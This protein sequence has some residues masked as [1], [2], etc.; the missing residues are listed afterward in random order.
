MLSKN[1]VAVSSAANFID[2]PGISPF[3]PS[4][5]YPELQ[6]MVSI[7]MEQNEVYPLLR[8]TMHSLEMDSARWG[9]TSWNPLAEII[10]PGQNVLIKPNL[11]RHLHLS[12]GDY[13]AVVTHGSVIRAVLDYVALALKGEGSIIVGDAPV[14]SADFNKIIEKTDLREVCEDVSQTWGVPISIVDFRLWT[15]QLDK[16]HCVTSS[17]DLPGDPN[18]YIAVDLSNK[19]LLAPISD[20]FERFRVTNYDCEEMRKHHNQVKHEYL[21]ARSVLNA[22]VVINLPKLKTH[23]K[24][25]LTAA[26]KNVVGINGHKDWLPHHRYGSV[27][28]GGDEYL[29][30]SILKR[31]RSR[32]LQ[33]IDREPYS[34]MNSYLRMI[35]RVLSRLSRHISGDLF[36]EGSWYGNDT[37][38]RTV[39]DLNRVV[40]YANKDGIMCDS[41]QRK[42]L[43]I[44]DGII[45]GEGEGPME[46]DRKQCGILVGGIN[47]VAVD[48]ALATLV[49]FDYRKVPVISNAFGI[50]DWPI[51]EFSPK[52]IQIFTNNSR[53]D[54]LR[55]GCSFR[56][57]CLKPPSGWSGH[58]ELTNA[59]NDD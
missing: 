13:R 16:N 36:E 26:L 24:V 32:L 9:T 55:I 10:Q 5:V 48:A 34:K 53:F 37:L 54:D 3:R 31:L 56:E 47:P 59:D 38:W 21:I 4:E 40:I 2:Y 39:L 22:D 6:G 50:K 23:R 19:S 27:K 30:S 46:P 11:V 51:A 29:H 58:I 44:V 25:G 45:A 33:K 8:E 18:G 14:Q 15:V 17:S 57:F 41:P 12:G 28:E 7:G 42:F 20:G 49:G 52:A 1:T 35:V 43:T